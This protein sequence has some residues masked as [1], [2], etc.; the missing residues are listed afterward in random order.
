M[1]DTFRQC[2]PSYCGFFGVQITIYVLSKI[3][4]WDCEGWRVGCLS[5]Y[6]TQGTAWDCWMPI[7]IPDMENYGNGVSERTG[8]DDRWNSVCCEGPACPPSSFWPQAAV[9]PHH[10]WCY[11]TISASWIVPWACACFLVPIHWFPP[12]I[13]TSMALQIWF[14]RTLTWSSQ[15]LSAIATFLSGSMSLSLVLSP[16]HFIGC[17]I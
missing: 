16:G 6:Q 10:R 3:H 1:L 12:C 17:C 2:L 4:V 13:F 7:W 11:D 5:E 14:S 15:L 9:Q 8:R